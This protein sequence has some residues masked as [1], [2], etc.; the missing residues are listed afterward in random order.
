MCNYQ[1]TTIFYKYDRNSINIV[2]F[3]DNRQNPDAL[4]RELK[5]KK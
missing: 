1:K 5:D 3:F 2:T 4:N